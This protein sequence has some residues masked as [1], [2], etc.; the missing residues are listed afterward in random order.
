KEIRR[1]F[2]GAGYSKMPQVL[3]PALYAQVML[4]HAIKRLSIKTGEVAKSSA[5]RKAVPEVVNHG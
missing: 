4:R 5:E 3:A 2:S 1:L